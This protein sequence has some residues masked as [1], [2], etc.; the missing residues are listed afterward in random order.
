M[1]TTR[2]A[3]AVALMTVLLSG[4]AHAV[5]GTPQANPGDAAKASADA[6]DRGMKAFTDH[7]NNISDEQGHSYYYARYGGKTLNR[8]VDNLM[9]GDP[10]ALLSKIKGAKDGDDFD[11]FHPAGSDLDYVRLGANL[12]KLEPTPWVSMSTVFPRDGFFTPCSLDGISSACGLSQAL[13]QTKLESP[14][15]LTKEA[16][17]NP[18]GTVEIHT[19]VT[20]NNFLEYKVMVFGE[21]VK[22]QLTPEMLKSVIPVTIT[23]DSSGQFL[24]FELRTTIEGEPTPLELQLGYEAHGKAAK[25]DFPSLPGADQITAIT[26][27]AAETKFW[28]DVYNIQGQ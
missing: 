16:R 12:A 26:D 22:K 25:E 11:K 19:G 7:F 3:S 17:R 5:P 15:G 8:E 20:L 13:G 2:P 6:Y 4:C 14:D 27:K 28:D 24:K 10:P 9:V 1:R 21:A 23:L 18:D